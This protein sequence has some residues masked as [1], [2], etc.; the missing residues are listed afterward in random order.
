MSPRSLT[1]VLGLLSFVM[2]CATAAPPP[3]SPPPAPAVAEAP[4]PA[5][6]P[7]VATI[8]GAK[9][10][11]AEL[12]AHVAETKLERTAALD[13]LIDLHLLRA[14][15]GAAGIAAPK[16]PTDRAKVELELARKLSLDVPPGGDVLIVDHAWVKDAKKKATTAKQ[17][18]SLEDLRA[19]VVAGKTI[20]KAFETLPGVDGKAW[21]IGDHEEYPYAVVPAE[22]HDLAPGGI[23]PIV[24]GDGGLHLFQIYSRKQT[25]PPAD[26][27]HQLVRDTLRNG[28]Q[29][30]IV[31]ATAAN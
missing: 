26:A 16:A 1:P 20:P 13:D 11:Q 17:K 29:I 22:A 30:E 3:A 6:S 21:H 27:V 9:V 14:A 28:K 7:T 5:P 25:P 2:A 19:E 15:C 8:D 4:P 12:D 18:K 10:T 24:A 31:E 23:S